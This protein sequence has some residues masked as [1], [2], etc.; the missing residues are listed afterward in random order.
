MFATFE[1]KICP[2]RTSQRSSE[3]SETLHTRDD[4]EKEPLALN[5][6]DR[7]N[8]P[9]SHFLDLFRWYPARFQLPFRSCANPSRL[10]SKRWSKHQSNSRRVPNACL[11]CPLCLHLFSRHRCCNLKVRNFIEDAILF[12][13]VGYQDLLPIWF[14][15]SSGFAF[16]FN[17]VNKICSRLIKWYISFW[18]V[19][20]VRSPCS[21]WNNWLCTSKWTIYNCNC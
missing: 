14:D 19:A 13:K 1:M 3:V 6:D 16:R 18:V 17:S 21:V 9:T 2:S 20:I 7:G 4:Y 12:F 11:Q 5:V 8:G 15:G 10:Q